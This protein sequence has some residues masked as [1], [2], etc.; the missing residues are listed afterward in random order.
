FDGDSFDF[1]I[2]QLLGNPFVNTS[3]APSSE[4]GVEASERQGGINAEHIGNPTF[5]TADFADP[6]GNLRV[7]YVL[8]SKNLQIQDA[9]VFWPTSDDPL[10]PLVGDFD[11]S[12]PGGFPSSDHRLIWAD[13][14]VASADNLLPVVLPTLETPPV[15]DIEEPPSGPALASAD[16]PA[17]YV[18][19]TDSALSLVITALKNGGLQVH[20]LDGELLQTIAPEDPEDLRYNNVDVLYGFQLGDETVD[21]AIAS[22]RANDTIAIFRIDPTTRQLTNITAN[23]VPETIFG[24]DDGEQTAYGLANYISPVLGNAYTFVTQS[25]GNQIAQLQ[26]IDTGEGRITAE[27]VRMFSVPIP[28]DEDL[29]ALTEGVVA[30]YELGYVY[31]GQEDVGIWKFSAEPDSK[32]PGVLIDRVK[33]EG[34]ALEADVE[35]LT[36]YYGADGTGYLLASS[37][38][39]STFAVYSREGNNDYLGNFIVGERNGIDRTDG[40]DGLDVINVP[41]GSQFP[42][43]LLVVHDEENSPALLVNDDGEL[44]NVSGN[45]KFVDW[46]AVANAFPMPLAIDPDSFDPRHPGAFS[47]VNGVA[48]GDTTQDSTVLWTRSTFL[49]DVNFAYG[50]DALFGDVLGTVTATV[51]DPM[52]PVKVSLTDLEP[53]TT[54]FYR[55]TDAAGATA[56][57]QFTTSQPVGNHTGLRFG[58]TGDWQQAPPYPS[59]ANVADRNLEFFLKLGDTIY[60]DTETP[61]LPGVSQARTLSDFRTKQEE[62]VSTRFGLNTVRDLYAS[63]SV[64]VT[65]D[66]H[67]LVDNFAGGAAPGD[68]PDAPDIGSSDEPLFV[69]DVPFVNETQAY[70]DALQAFQEYHPIQDRFYG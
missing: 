31:I 60:A 41:L 26:L 44:S 20:N 21:L 14:T 18:H 49:G 55:A 10:F 34:K 48:S 54:Y 40:S 69:D 24:V 1:A 4:G 57:G 64:L 8:P 58:F 43:G 29:E 5:D 12:L 22:D 59:L 9:Q 36:I 38:G 6:P 56:T 47:L 61:A 25:D 42:N 66:D 67:E 28:E 53:G 51:T 39:D 46:A 37:Q 17:I 30:D 3:L 52:Q 33:P 35:G 15:F 45:F 13:L 70:Q 16:D 2:R 7:D 32:E 68:S 27:I 11:P 65:I 63:T 19:P 62:V 50:T 23:N